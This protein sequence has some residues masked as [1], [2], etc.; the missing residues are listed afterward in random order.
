[1]ERRWPG[2]RRK[3]VAVTERKEVVMKQLCAA[4]M[5]A[6]VLAVVFASSSARVEA[7]DKTVS[8]TVA[9]I[10]PDSL[11]IN[12]RDEVVKL[13]VD[14]KTTVIGVGVGTKTAKMKA[15]KKSPQ[16]VDLVNTGDQVSA[17]YDDSSKHASEVRITKPAPPAK[18]K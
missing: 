15:E 18:T 12:A 7:A 2:S 17:K 14:S 8:G 3:S 6:L 13:S 11:T 9:A 16:I 5:G 10:S 1:M 4:S